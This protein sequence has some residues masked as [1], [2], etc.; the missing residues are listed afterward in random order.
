MVEVARVRADGLVRCERATNQFDQNDVTMTEGWIFPR[1]CERARPPR[2][3]VL[4]FSDIVW[5]GC[6]FHFQ[7]GAPA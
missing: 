7:T 3:F 1:I 4:G 2:P 5:D 6:N